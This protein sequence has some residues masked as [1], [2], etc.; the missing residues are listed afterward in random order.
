MKRSRIAIYKSL[1]FG[2]LCAATLMAATVNTALAVDFASIYSENFDSMGTAG[3]TPPAGW[4]VKTG[5]SG[6]INSTWT[7]SITANGTNSVASMVV[8]PTPLT[9]IAAPTANNNNGYNA[10]G[11]SAADRVLA[12]SPTSISGSALELSLTNTSGAPINSLQ[13]RYDIRRYT[14]ASAAN[15][16]PGYWLFYSLDNGTTWSNVSTLNPVISGSSGVVVP[17]TAGVTTVPGTTIALSSPWAANSTLLL[18]WVD[19]N[20]VA[21]SPDQIIGLDNVSIALAPATANTALFLNG[22][23][24]YAT[25]GAATATLGASSLTIECRFM[26]TGAGVTTSTG[27][28]GVTAIPLVTKGRGEADGDNRDCNYFL[29]INASGL[30][31]ADF[32]AQAGVSGITAGQNYPVTGTNAPIQNNVWYHA[33]AVYDV[34]SHTWKLYLDGMEVGTSTPPAGAAP[35]NDSIQHFGIGTALNSNGAAA[36][37]FQGVIDEARVWNVAR[38]ASEISAG[39]DQQITSATPGLLAVYGLNEG[40]GATASAIPATAP[41]GTIVNSP[42]WVD[43][44]TASGNQAPTVNFTQPHSGSMV[45]GFAPAVI[46]MTVD[47]N[48]SDGSVAKVEF[49]RNGSVIATITSAPY[50]F[51]DTDLGAGRYSYTARATDNQG[52]VSTSAPFNAAIT[53]DPNNHPANTALLFDG[54]NDYVTMGVAPELNVGGP[55]SNGFTLETWFRKEGTGLTSGSGSGGVTAVPLFG[56]GRGE[57]DGSNVDCNYFFG[58]NA[59]GQLVADFEAYPASGISSG[60]NYP[61]TGTNTPITNGVWHHAAVTYDGNSS[62]W[63]LY[64]DGVQV[65]SATAANGA[66]PRYDS[67]QHFGIGAAFNSSGAAE[68]AFAG[69]MDEI[70]VWNYARSAAEIAAAKDYEIASA[71]GLIGRFGLNEAIGSTAANSTGTSVGTLTNGPIWVEGA[72]FI[73]INT[74]PSVTL[75]APLSGATSFMPYPVVFS[76]SA[77][78]SD[79]YISKVEYF[80]NNQKAGES[81]SAPF[82]FT[83]TPPATGSYSV[84]A[85]ATDNLGAGA[86]SSPVSITIEPNPNKAPVVTLLSPAN[87]STSFGPTAQ[88]TAGIADPEGDATTTTFYGRTKSTATPGPDFSVIILPDTQ[89]YAQ[90]SSLAPI[91]KAQT[92]WIVDNRISRNIAFVNHVGDITNDGDNIPAQ[93]DNVNA[94]LPLLENPATTGLP[95]GIPYGILPGNHDLLPGNE[96][97]TGALYNQYYGVSHFSGRSYYGGHYGG[98]NNNSYQFFSASGMDFIVINLAYRPAADPAILDWADA[99][100]KQYPNHRAIVNSH[101]IINTGNPASFGGQGQAIYDRLK[102]NPNLFLMNCGHVHGEGYRADSFDGRTVHTILTDYQ[103]TANGG[104][105]FLRIL[106]FRPASNTI[107]VESYSPT[108][109]RAVNSSDGVVAWG[110]AYDLPY[111]MSGQ[112]AP[113]SLLGTVSAPSGATA[114]T[115]PWSSLAADTPYEWYAWVTDGINLTTTTPT[116]FVT[117]PA[118][119]QQ[120]ISSQ[121]TTTTSSFVYNRATKLYTGKLTI[122]NT[123]QEALAG[124]FVIWLNSLTS[125]VT[126]TNGNGSFNG[127]PHIDPAAPS[128]LLPGASFSVPLSFSNPANMKINFTPVTFN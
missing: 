79:G 16:L 11:A 4:S 96:N 121:V 123:S 17:N 86:A 66:L 44:F 48:D 101:W 107:H 52:A 59:S 10:Q 41:A 55:P 117:S 18:R 33:A 34:P 21:T 102:N 1:L 108:L 106:T 70:R 40:T 99:L 50:T 58:I 73:G 128:G 23:N 13:V 69:R 36:G 46:A 113:F 88:L 61:V 89:F 20:A 78:D 68:G 60:Q 84:S 103:S 27:T 74:A 53:F 65:G 122:T 12:T 35:R 112:V 116:T 77:S 56:K 19:D 111:T 39:K 114:A 76:V 87:N 83:W 91:F 94:A 115:F 125:G 75:D 62:T 32:E 97:A 100:L 5:N 31:V 109:G 105:G 9:A 51:T 37:F 85:R 49:I 63:K 7:T 120:D 90:N 67:I 26:K 25:M 54:V 47:A 110:G 8:A 14:A 98:N 80:V 2:S 3:T 71:A 29:G 124:P 72:P 42:L 45:F 127:Y 64:L 82:S 22:A 92:Q 24:Q 57:S 126:L 6:T 38:T 81:T 15:E 43:G 118:N 119:A 30:L 28:G 93:W 95:Y 104:N